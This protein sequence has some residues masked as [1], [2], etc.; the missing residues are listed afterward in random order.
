[1]SDF[2]NQ[3]WFWPALIIVVGL[4]LL[5]LLLTEV[6]NFLARRRSSYARPVQLLRNYVLPACALFL[7]ID[8][9]EHTNV[10][11]TW[12]RIAATVFGF[13][14]MLF[15]LSGANAV[16][17]GEARAD[18]WRKRLPTIFVDLGRLL[19]IVVGIGI[20]LSWVWGTDIGGLI[21]AVGVTSIVIGLAVQSAVG[22][23]IAG[24]LMLFEQPFRIGDWLDAPDA[25]GR[26]VEVNWRSVHIDTGNGIKI[27]PNAALATDSFTNLSR[28][29]G[30][31][32]RATVTLCFTAADRPGTVKAT[33]LAVADALPAKLRGLPAQVSALGESGYRVSVPIAS[34]ADEGSTKTQLLHR[35][36]YAAQRAGLHLDDADNSPEQSAQYVEA[37]LKIVA[38]SLGLDDEALAIMAA[39]GRC[40]M[41]AEGEVIQRADSV[42]DAIGFITEGSVTMVVYTKDGIEVTVGHLEAGD[43]IGTTALTRQRVVS[44]VVATAD[45]TLISVPRDAITAVV[46]ANPRLARRLGEAIEM[47]RAAAAAALAGAV[48]AGR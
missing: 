42:P 34:P 23:V 12:S 29:E 1:M 47:R 9:V 13:L 32:Y 19:L 17:F 36:W 22:P 30:A 31:A 2:T 20:L 15:L 27:I 16:L 41:Y 18:S 48:D 46:R 6:A 44:G 7:L 45:T 21:T 11:A 28:V 14:V 33:L 37:Q 5:L 8:Q 4:P 3:D 10:H 24:L 26:V 35:A 40:L 39:H 43:Y 25:R 38:G